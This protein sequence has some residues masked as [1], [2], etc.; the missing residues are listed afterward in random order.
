M[1]TD[2]KLSIAN[3]EA[4]KYEKNPTNSSILPKEMLIQ[5]FFL[6]KSRKKA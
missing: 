4:E 2:N 6:K 5:V 3:A 1:E